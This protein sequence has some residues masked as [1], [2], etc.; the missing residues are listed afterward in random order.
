M[1]REL[2]SISASIPLASRSSSATHTF[3]T[4]DS[5]LAELGFGGGLRRELDASQSCVNAVAGQKLS[6]RPL[7]DDAAVLEHD[8]PVRVLD[9]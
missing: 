6:V 3:R 8:D 1:S 2:C 4:R 9:R 5:K 7:F